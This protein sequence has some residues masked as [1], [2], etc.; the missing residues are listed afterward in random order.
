MCYYFI[1]KRKPKDHSWI[2]EADDFVFVVS[3]SLEPV[4]QETED[5]KVQY[6]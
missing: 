2:V 5:I 1:V 3:T 6:I 4:L